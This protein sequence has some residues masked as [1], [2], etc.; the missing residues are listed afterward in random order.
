MSFRAREEK[1]DENNSSKEALQVMIACLQESRVQA[2]VHW[3][4]VDLNGG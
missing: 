2:Y 3:W 4:D 1:F